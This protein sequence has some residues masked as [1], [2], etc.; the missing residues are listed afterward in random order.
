MKRLEQG[1]IS[2]LKKTFKS[3]QF[4]QAFDLVYEK[5][6]PHMGI[7]LLRGELLLTLRNKIADKVEPGTLLGLHQLLHNI[8][9]KMGIKVMP[10]TEILLLQ[11][12]EILDA[13]HDPASELNP[14]LTSQLE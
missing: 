12:S 8:P 1:D 10:N 2:L 14:I 7:L 5:Q 3:F 6:V 13:L 11:K 9:L 4:H